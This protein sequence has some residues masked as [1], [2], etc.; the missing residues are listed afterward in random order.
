MI[1]QLSRSERQLALVILIVLAVLGLLMAVAGRNDPLGGQGAVVLVL[2][3]A[4]IFAVISRYY[5]PEPSDERF[6]HYY[7]D[8]TKAGIVLAM[9][10]VAFGLFVG[11]WVAWL[12]VI[13][14]LTFAPAWSPFHP[15]LTIHSPT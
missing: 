2:T 3:I 15:L 12:L 4:A 9:G 10:W 13:P 7:D 8:P 6:N 14:H 5:D 1:G 11:D